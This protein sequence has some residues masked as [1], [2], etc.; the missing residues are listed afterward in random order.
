MQPIGTFQK[1]TLFMSLELKSE[2]LE[3][4]R[5]LSILQLFRSGRIT[6]Y[7]M[8]FLGDAGC[9][10]ASEPVHSRPPGIQLETVI[11]DLFT[12]FRGLN[13]FKCRWMF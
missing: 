5:N 1:L 2:P 6:M 12:N 4:S 13:C 3:T 11:A 10:E 8:L 7:R 9:E